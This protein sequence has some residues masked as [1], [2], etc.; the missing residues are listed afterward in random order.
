MPEPLLFWL[1]VL[2]FSAAVVVGVLALSTTIRLKAMYKTE[3]D[4]P[5]TG[6]ADA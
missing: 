6:T 5:E 4:Y 1:T 3:E 2:L